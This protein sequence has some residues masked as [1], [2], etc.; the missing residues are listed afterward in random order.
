MFICKDDIV[1][2]EMV[3]LLEIAFTVISVQQGLLWFYLLKL[4]LQ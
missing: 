3:K 2:A 4:L 1:Q